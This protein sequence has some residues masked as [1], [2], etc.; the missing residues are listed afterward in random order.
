[1][2]GGCQRSRTTICC[3]LL[4]GNR[5][6]WVLDST[7]LLLLLLRCAGAWSSLPSAQACTNLPLVIGR[8]TVK[9]R[10]RTPAAA[11]AVAALCR[12]LV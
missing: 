7:A 2:A 8:A 4:A 5:Q 11:A 9:L 1:M 3:T 12:H 10:S 6:A